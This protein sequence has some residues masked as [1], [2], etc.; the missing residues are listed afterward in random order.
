MRL[1][2]LLRMVGLPIPWPDLG[3]DHRRLPRRTASRRD[4]DDQQAKAIVGGQPDNQPRHPWT[5]QVLGVLR[6]V[7][8]RSPR[9]SGHGS[10]PRDTRSDSPGRDQLLHLPNDVVHD[11]HL[12]PQLEPETNL[13]RFAL[14]VCFFPQLVAGPIERARRLLPQIR[15]SRSHQ[16][17][18]TGW[19]RDS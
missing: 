9:F 13:A 19:G 14:F 7:S 17:R 6:R 15:V 3:L 2:R 8:R 11:R 18:P 10:K 16:P 1:L 12:S 4:R 5:F